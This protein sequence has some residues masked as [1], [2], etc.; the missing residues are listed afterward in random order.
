MGERYPAGSKLDRLDEPAD[1]E[2]AFGSGLLN[3]SGVARRQSANDQRERKPQLGEL[4]SASLPTLHLAEYRLP[5]RLGQA[6][7]RLRR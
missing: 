2:N 3:L 1:I 4:H 5:T 6:A 7:R